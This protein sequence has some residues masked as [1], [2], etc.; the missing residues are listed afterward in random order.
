VIPIAMPLLT[1]EE[2]DAARAVVLSG[3]VSQGLAE[4]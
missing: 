1:N 2:A 4:F 3:W